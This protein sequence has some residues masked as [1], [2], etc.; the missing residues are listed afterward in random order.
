MANT[1]TKDE[2]FVRDEL[3]KVYPQLVINMRKVCGSGYDRWGDD[4]L[5]VAVTFFLE[6]PLEQ[7]LKTINDGKLENFITWIANM[8]LKSSSSRFFY[9]YRH[10]NSKYREL[11]HDY[12]YV[13]EE[14]EDLEEAL[15]CVEAEVNN[16]PE[17]YKGF[18]L[19]MLYK[20]ASMSQCVAK[21]GEGS[22]TFKKKMNKYLTQIEKKCQ[23]CI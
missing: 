14:E 12:G 10:P 13:I 19:D 15:Q 17:P 3:T 23:H 21:T 1:L 5:A 7:Q 16:I 11:Y 22:H 4:L 20:K 2:K 6:K 9:T 18:L 8:Q